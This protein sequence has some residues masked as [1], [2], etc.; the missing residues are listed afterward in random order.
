MKKKQQQAQTSLKLVA[1]MVALSVATLLLA[2]FQWVE[3][4]ALRRGERPSCAIDATFNCEAVWNSELAH[5]LHSLLGVPVAG[6]GVVWGTAA[7]VVSGA[8]FWRL[9]SGRE[10]VEALV[11]ASRLMAVAAVMAIAVFAIESFRTGSVCLTCLGTYAFTG[12]FAIIAKLASDLPLR[13]RTQ[14]LGAG[15]QWAVFPVVGAYALALVVA[16][17]VPTKKVSSAELVA[18]A[19]SPEV[20]NAGT[21][22]EQK[23]QAYLAALPP[24]HRQA[25]SDMLD[26]YRLAKPRGT[27]PP[28]RTRYGT[29]EAP[30]QIVEF[31]DIRCG[32][33]RSLSETLRLLKQV[34]PAGT[35][36]IEPRYYPLDSG[37]NKGMQGSDGTGVRCVGA[38]AQICLEQAP[39]F[40]PLREKL[41]D[42]QASLNTPEDVLRIASS[43]SVS[44]SQLDACLADPQTEAKLQADIRYG[45]EQGLRGTPLVLVNGKQGSPVGPF[46]FALAMTR[47][48]PDSAVFNTLPKPQPHDHAH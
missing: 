20:Q 33:C 13:P 16:L 44:R 27:L 45:D 47:G 26:E 38:K 30:V 17:N 48:N 7:L 21:D 25:L 6:L 23:L 32:H 37:C 19:Q 9:R 40:W 24:E 31:T 46:L 41:F 4:A 43:G 14:A 2:I 18:R 10:D 5:G 29:A 1:A 36:A 3:L 11:F 28:P 35:L 8:L 12:T 15:L 22:S 34:V 39:D 42:N